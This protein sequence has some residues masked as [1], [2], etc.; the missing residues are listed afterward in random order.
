MN[1]Q[2]ANNSTVTEVSRPPSTITIGG[3]AN[4]SVDIRTEELQQAMHDL[5]N[6]VLDLLEPSPAAPPTSQNTL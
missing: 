3:S 5:G 6:I 4:D 1:T 2:Q